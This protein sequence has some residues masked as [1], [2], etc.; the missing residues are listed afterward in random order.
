MLPKQAAR[1]PPLTPEFLAEMLGVRRTSVTEVA[2]GLQKQGL[3]R[4]RRGTIEIVGGNALA[5]RAC[6]CHETVRSATSALMRR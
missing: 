6:E 1:L 3:I 2:K 5:Q 4:Y